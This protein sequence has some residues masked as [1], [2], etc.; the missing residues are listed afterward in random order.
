DTMK[1]TP[2]RLGSTGGVGGTVNVALKEMRS[3]S[4][5]PPSF[6]SVSLCLIIRGPV[7][8]HGSQASPRP[9]PSTS[10]CPPLATAAQ[11]SWTSHTVSPSP[12]GEIGPVSGGQAALDPVQLS[13]MA[14][15]HTCVAGSSR[16]GGQAALDPVQ[17]STASQR[18][19]LVRQTAVDGAKASA[20]QTALEP[21]HRSATS[22]IPA[23]ERQSVPDGSNRHNGEQQ[24]P[25]T[26]LPS[27]HCS[28]NSTTVFPQIA[29]AGVAPNARRPTN[30]T[31]PTSSD[32]GKRM[33]FVCDASTIP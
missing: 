24:S 10:S 20:G 22:Q 27:S 4:A 29:A 7:L 14:G 25:P 30:A 23:L 16:S 21:V 13:S 12:S 17:R 26:R 31:A 19:A 8:L 3:S 9:S 15:R 5:A 1:R 32:L 18:S 2:C 28:P 33:F 11:L 6:V